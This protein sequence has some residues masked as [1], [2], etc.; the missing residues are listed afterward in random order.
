MG[1]CG[2]R[3]KAPTPFLIPTP[4]REKPQAPFKQSTSRLMGRVTEILRP[5]HQHQPM[6]LSTLL[7]YLRPKQLGAS[8]PPPVITPAPSQPHRSRDSANRARARGRLSL[9]AVPACFPAWGLVTSSHMHLSPALQCKA[10]ER[11]LLLNLPL[12]HGCYDLELVP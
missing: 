10:G 8:H 3:R 6:T 5:Q 4:H 12:I 2:V 11:P 7:P 9:R 1:G